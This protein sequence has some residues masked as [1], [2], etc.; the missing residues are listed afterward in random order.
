[1]K[2]VIVLAAVLSALAVGETDAQQRGA[3]PGGSYRD[4]CR[5]IM[6]FS[7]GDDSVLVAQCRDQGG[8]WRGASLRVGRCRDVMN[9][10]GDLMCRDGGPGGPGGPG[11]GFPGGPGG[12]GGGRPPLGGSA[13]LFSGVD[14]GGQAFSTREEVTNL[15]RQYNDKAMSLKVDGGAWTVCADSDFGGR[16]QT[17]DRDVRDLRQFGLGEAISSMRRS[18]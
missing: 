16:C 14:F 12:P 5:D 6:T 1:M 15:P 4:S 10:D 3:T 11:G 9:R 8:R 7:L 13:T 18:R 17:F 2:R